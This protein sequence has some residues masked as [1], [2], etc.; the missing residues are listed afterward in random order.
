MKSREAPASP[1]FETC[2]LLD[3]CADISIACHTAEHLQTGD[4]FHSLQ[5]KTGFE[6]SC[7]VYP[8]G[9]PKSKLYYRAQEQFEGRQGE[10]MLFKQLEKD[11]RDCINRQ[12]MPFLR[13]MA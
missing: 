12:M 3:T 7:V 5:E 6:M 1:W 2:L 11:S 10:D 13:G 9:A 4:S 8:S